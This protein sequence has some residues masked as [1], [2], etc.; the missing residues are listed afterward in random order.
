MSTISNAKL[1]DTKGLQVVVGLGKTGLSCI[2]HLTRLGCQ[3]AVTDS[4]DNPPELNEIQNHFP[5]VKLSLGG[6]NRLLCARAHRLIVSPGVSTHE[7]EIAQAAAR[8]IPIIGDIELFAQQ[9]QAPMVA[10]TGSNGKSTVTSLVGDMAKAAGLKVKVGGNLGT[11]A[12]DL[13]EEVPPDLY[14]LELSS[15]QLETTYSLKTL[16]A[17]LLNISAD[18]M[19]RYQNLTEYLQA[20]QRIYHHCQTA[21]INRDDPVTWQNLD[22]PHSISFGLDVP[23]KN[24]FGLLFSDN[25]CYLAC[26]HHQLIAAN[27]LKIRGRHQM[28]NAL[29]AFGLGKAIGLSDRAML[30]ALKN[31]QGLP[32]R[33]QWVANIH[34]VNWYNDSKATNVGAALAS[35]E[36][37]GQ[38]SSKKLIV[39]AGGIGK[40]ADFSALVPGMKKYVRLLILMGQ[41]APIITEALKDSIPIHQAQTLQQAVAIAHQEAQPGETVILAPACASFDQFHHFEHRGDVFMQAVKALK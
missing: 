9:A 26:G 28:A 6:F 24:N 14:V 4:R 25:L 5:E 8:G 41:D 7:P 39:I 15:F 33:C 36:G 23:E 11:P 22:L 34:G 37:L 20:K 18:H 40:N 3:I 12:L 35:I 30:S 21:V 31:F 10:V 32:H 29:A 27:D 19:D 38:E 17:T 13:L 1:Y 2:R 16:A